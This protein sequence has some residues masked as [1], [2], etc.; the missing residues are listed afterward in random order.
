MSSDLAAPTGLAI[1]NV[2]DAG[3]LQDYR[4]AWIEGFEEPEEVADAFGAV[5]LALGFGGESPMRHYVAFL[6]GSPV[7]TASLFLGDRVSELF[8]VATVPGARRLGIGSAIAVAA[9]R[10]AVSLGYKVA[11]LHAS[12][13]GTNIYRRLGFRELAKVSVYTWPG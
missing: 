2:G 11:T 12:E 8:S 5:Y 3:A 4:R 7:A 6:D 9:L 10:A 1:R 13:M